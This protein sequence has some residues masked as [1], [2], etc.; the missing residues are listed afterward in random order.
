MADP[1][2]VKTRKVPNETSDPTQDTALTEKEVEEVAGGI[3]NTEDGIGCTTS[4][5]R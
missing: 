5:G 4:E 1:G 2:E 3:S